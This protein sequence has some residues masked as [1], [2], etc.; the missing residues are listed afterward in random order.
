[1]CETSGA[2]QK[3]RICQFQSLS[4]R[5]TINGI[6]VKFCSKYKYSQIRTNVIKFPPNISSETPFDSKQIRALNLIWLAAQV[7][8]P[9]ISNS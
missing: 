4:Y 2:S 3:V 7:L 8:Q 9:T 5:D 1:M 6:L